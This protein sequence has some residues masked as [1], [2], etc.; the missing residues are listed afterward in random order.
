MIPEK[1]QNTS[2]QDD[3]KEALESA[4]S[5]AEN[6]VINDVL[7]SDS[8]DVS[9]LL[10]PMQAIYPDVRFRT[11]WVYRSLFVCLTQQLSSIHEQ[12]HMM[13]CSLGGAS[14]S[15]SS[16][17]PDSLNCIK[18]NLVQQLTKLVHLT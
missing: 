18:P 13:K 15:S 6:S 12:Y 2:E 14:S 7:Q 8:I 1:A 17:P 11:R 4:L 5:M 3:M 10:L 9:L 16:K